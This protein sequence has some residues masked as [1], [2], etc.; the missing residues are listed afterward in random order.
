MAS[1]ERGVFEALEHGYLN[2]IQFFIAG[3]RDASSS[4]HERYTLTVK[5]AGDEEQLER[6]IQTVELSTS[7]AK[8][9][10]SAMSSFKKA[11]QVLLKSLENLPPLPSK[12]TQN[13]QAI[14][15]HQNEY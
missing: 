14:N 12:P 11:V 2:A 4:V 13:L 3:A 5:Y 8:S 15:L 1:Q 7:G 9:V 6:A 10:V